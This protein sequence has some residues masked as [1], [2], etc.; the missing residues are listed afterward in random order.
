M[1]LLTFIL[2]LLACCH[3]YTKCC[4][5]FT[6]EIEPQDVIPKRVSLGSK[7]I[8]ML[9]SSLLPQLPIAVVHVCGDCV[10]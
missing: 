3:T 2:K 6:V 8:E 5:T 4:C 10:Q 7:Y 9:L 1:F